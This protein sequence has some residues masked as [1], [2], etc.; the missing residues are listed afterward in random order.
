ME[1][2]PPA[3]AAATQLTFEEARVFGCL[4]EKSQATP[5]YYPMTLN[6]LVNACNQKSSREPVVA[7][8][9]DIVDEALNQLREKG[10]VAFASGVGRVVKYIHRAGHNGLG[11]TPAQAAVLSIIILRGPQTAGEIKARTGRQFNFPSLESVQEAI[12]CMMTTEKP[13]LEEAPKRLGQKEIRFRHRFFPFTESC[14]EDGGSSAL[15]APSLTK[16]L[17]EVMESLHA[18]KQENQSLH[19][20]LTA[21]EEAFQKI[22]K[23]LY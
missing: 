14:E 8:D 22:N 5:E 19:Q 20:R 17:L 16:G 11:L 13:F 21:L 10:L 4:I 15:R 2:Q 12:T 3:D 6:A 7:F 1:E 18:L 23:D 9:E